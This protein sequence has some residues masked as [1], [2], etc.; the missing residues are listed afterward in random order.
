M[1]IKNKEFLILGLNIK[2]LG[3]LN[4][5]EN[6]ISYFRKNQ[7]IKKKIHNFKFFLSEKLN[8]TLELKKNYSFFDFLKFF[9]LE[10]FY[11]KN[12]K[13]INLGDYPLP[14]KKKQIIFVNQANL[15]KPNLY[16]YS[17]ISFKFKIRRIYFG[18]FCNSVELFIVQSK[19]MKKFISKSYG[20][21]LKK[22]IIFNPI[23]NQFKIKKM[24]KIKNR[25]IIKLLYP[26]S[27]YSYK[28]HSIIKNTLKKFKL[29]NFEIY[30]TASTKEFEKYKNI[31]GLKRINY[32]DHKD[33]SKIFQ[34]FHGLIFPSLIESLGL[35]LLEAKLYKIPVISCDLPFSREILE[36]KA[37]YFDPLS[38]FSLL[39][40]LNKFKKEFKKTINYPNAQQ[41]KDDIIK[42]FK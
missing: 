17:S 30:F 9:F 18:L 32:Y 28:N 15:I 33:T 11:K 16:K 25:S 1:K 34:K 37:Y 38:A 12:Y 13:W 21:N 42:I 27:H 3:S 4:W 35:P 19:F 22:I 31:S 23:H 5:S 10:F 8:N 24:R 40:A 20:I 7:H 14:F 41:P 36:K 6:I 2:G 26:S 39:N 29:K